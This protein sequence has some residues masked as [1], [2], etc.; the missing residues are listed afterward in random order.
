MGPFG[1]SG[2]GAGQIGMGTSGLCGCGSVGVESG[3]KDEERGCEVEG[4]WRSGEVGVWGCRGVM[5]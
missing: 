2:T 3:G 1:I 4:E 5:G